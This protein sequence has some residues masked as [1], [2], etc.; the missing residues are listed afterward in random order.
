MKKV[1]ICC[2]GGI[3]SKI[4]IRKLNQYQQENSLDYQFFSLSET[5]V[6][7]S[8]SDYD[9]VLFAPQT[10]PSIEYLKRLQQKCLQVK[11][12]PE[13]IY[14][15][16]ECALLIEFLNE[17]TNSKTIK[18][19]FDQI[20]YYLT[21]LSKHRLIK[22]LVNSSIALS[23]LMIVQALFSLLL[24]LP[25]GNSYQ[26][27]LTATNLKDFLEIPV[28]VISNSIG[29]FYSFAVAYHF[30]KGYMDC[31]FAGFLSLA[32]YLLL[33]PIDLNIQGG[34]ESIYT[35]LID[36]QFLNSSGVFVAMLS[37]LL[38]SLGY[39]KITKLFKDELMKF[40]FATIIML[41]IYLG[42]KYLFTLT[43]Y[44]NIFTFLNQAIL[45]LLEPISKGVWGFAIY[46]FL[47][48]L[49]Y[50]IGIH[51]SQLIYALIFPLYTTMY[52]A[53]INAFAANLPAPYPYWFLI[54]WVFIGGVGATLGLNLLM[55]FKSKSPANKTLG[56]LALATSLFN[57]NEP[58]IYGL[59]IVFNPL[60]AIPFVSIPLLN[61]MIC[62]LF[63]DLLAIVP[64]PTGSE[65]S[66]Y[67]PFPLG[68]LLT[69]H[70]YLGLLLCIGILIVDILCYY[71]FFKEYD[72][73]TIS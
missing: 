51:G 29:L 38:F 32:C 60:L 53:N 22:V 6:E 61:L 39:Q 57:I 65:I 40:S 17:T 9:I 50:F 11:V 44:H 67:M 28:L 49:L 21:K 62:Y 64:F 19:P 48:S 45:F 46:V 30:R 3:T 52:Y 15:K 35:A 26:N 4:F 59:P 41:S 43:V 70:S 12:I 58:L 8:I 14:G 56:K 66:V 24:S 23:S 5:F 13:S 69:N 42:I 27:F 33:I 1:L 55:I 34:L 63:M 72:K 36:L 18:K 25:L 37:A 54:P 71:P 68:A 73:Q 31:L 10:K 20:F 16:M 47:S 7:E 2:S